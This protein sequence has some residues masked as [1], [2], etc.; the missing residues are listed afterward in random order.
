MS[1]AIERQYAVQDSIKFPMIKAGSRDFAVAADW[2]PAQQDAKISIDGGALATCTN[3]IAI[4]VTGAAHWTLTLT[5][6]ELTGKKI[7]IQIVDAATK[8][9]EDQAIYIETYGSTSAQHAVNRNDTVRAGLTALPNVASGSAGAIPTTGSGTSQIQLSG[10][11]V[12]LATSG[13]DAVSMV[14]PPGVP[15]FST[16]NVRTAI[17][18]I[19]ALSRNKMTQD[20]TQQ[21]LRNNADSAPIATAAHSDAAGVYTRGKWT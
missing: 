17:A 2:T 21:V 4:G 3:T 13:L 9:V 8:A 15:D 12:A 18:W 19:M 5:T 7:M 6:T 14:E 10:G 11:G 16:G 1:G 20:A